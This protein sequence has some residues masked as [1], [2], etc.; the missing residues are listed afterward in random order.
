MSG[1]FTNDAEF[2]FTT[3]FDAKAT[4]VSEALDRLNTLTPAQLVN[5]LRSGIEALIEGQGA[6]ASV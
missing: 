3:F 4:A 5:Y 2:D 1:I 6:G